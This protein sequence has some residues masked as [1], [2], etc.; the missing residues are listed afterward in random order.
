[1]PAK[2]K[3][4]RSKP[5]SAAPTPATAT[6]AT[7]PPPDA[8]RRWVPFDASAYQ[9]TDAEV[10]QALTNE[11]QEPALTALFGAEE[12]RELRGLAEQVRS[13]TTVREARRRVLILP[14]IMGSKIGRRRKLI[15][16]DTVWIEPF[17]LLSGGL[18]RLT[19]P[20]PGDGFHAIGVMLTT[21]LLL[22]LRLK[23]AGFD[24]DFH[25]FD[26]RR[27]IADLGKE[28]A[29]RIAADP[30]R[31]V[32][33]VAHSM[34]GLVARAALNDPRTKKVR[35][36]IQQ[37]TPNFG[38]F[39]PVMALRGIHGLAKKL[40][41]IDLKHSNAR[42]T[43]QVFA[44][45]PGLYEMLPSTERYSRQD[46]YDPATWPGHGIRPRSELLAQA[47][48]LSSR[49]APPDDRFVLIAGINQDT[50]VGAR[51]ENGELVFEIS[52]AGDGTVPFEFARLNGIPIYF[53]DGG[54]HGAL[55]RHGKVIQATIELLRDGTPSE[56][57]DT[58]PPTVS[59]ST[60]VRSLR[61]SDLAR[62]EPPRQR[63]TPLTPEDLR[64]LLEGFCAQ[65]DRS[66][67]PLVAAVPGASSAS[68]PTATCTL[69]DPVS[70]SPSDNVNSVP[71][72]F[73][74]G[75]RRQHRLDVR[76][77]QGS[78]TQ[79]D[80]RAYVVG[81]LREVAPGGA[82]LAIDAKLGGTIRE[83]TQRRL[84]SGNVGEVFILPRGRAELRAEI[85]LFAG[86]GLF[87][88][89]N[90][91]VLRLVA[92]NIVR[93]LVHTHVEEFAT[94]LVGSGSSLS[95]DDAVTALF[96]GFVRG[97]LDTDS[98]HRFRAVQI[99]EPDP[100]RVAAIRRR[101]LE[102]FRSP[103]CRDL[104]VTFDE[105]R[106]LPEPALSTANERSPSLSSRPTPVY[107]LVRGEQ[108]KSDRLRLH[109]SVLTAGRKAAVLSGQTEVRLPDISKRLAALP[110]KT[111]AALRTAASEWSDL[112]LPPDVRAALADCSDRPVVVVHDAEGSRFPWEMILSEPRPPALENGVS[113]RFL[114]DR[115]SVAKWRA[116]R[117]QAPSLNVLL[118]VNPTEDLP[119]AEREAAK[120]R[121]VL[122]ELPAVQLTW[123]EGP[124][125][126]RRRILETLS[127]GRHDL[128]HYA[129]H[130]Y[131]DPLNPGRC[132]LVC[133]GQEIL[134]GADL[135]G[136]NNLPSLF[137]YNACESARVRSRQPDHHPIEADPNQTRALAALSVAEALLVGGAA[138]YLGTFWPV[139]DQAAADFASVF[140]REI[141]RGT[142]L[143][144]AL[145]AARRRLQNASSN[146]WADYLHY[147][148]PEFR[149]K[150][151]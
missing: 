120:V 131:F 25:P 46:F 41:S 89:F 69:D 62:L 68:I 125:A 74:F 55:P 23:A 1:M 17:D 67:P 95:L 13:R 123:I 118:V 19:L 66:A 112:L 109:S 151:G 105:R 26:W 70:S 18:A 60:G 75:R 137:F 142:A 78:I 45:F 9:M 102:L 145:V 12:L 32:W 134:T 87:D 110:P 8:L 101:L 96:T 11:Q 94:V 21:Y 57:P 79:V 51:L 33:L 27:P 107:L 3:R 147:G 38:S 31:E 116:E 5:Q 63:G 90:A 141:A 73:V 71:E 98:D 88:A 64:S 10:E 52:P 114:T 44:S 133:A 84:F 56:L 2:T 30:A 81:L 16:T 143:G 106:L 86:L 14:G 77:V 83:F 136:T 29:D 92:E 37:G 15:G 132:G 50:A 129:G 103:L 49:L 7:P 47:R 85:V 135:A 80:T 28:L 54:E 93:T 150:I 111:P 124:E 127:S 39:S 65:D 22:K 82:A 121:D 117:Q 99:C 20:T 48:G 144:P 4:S 35:R 119:G 72:R 126:T 113:R 59:R 58:A 91:E 100:E 146:D 140:Y 53:V 40:A 149:L 61:E 148:D 34:G 6:E 108:V 104:E 76:L 139:G 122:R 24:A 42:L 36:L 138:N 97:L 128:V 130:A 43:E 115:L